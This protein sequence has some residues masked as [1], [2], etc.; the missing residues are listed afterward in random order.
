MGLNLI[1]PQSTF[2][3]GGILFIMST[4]IKADSRNKNTNP[5]TSTTK[6]KTVRKKNVE[7]ASGSSKKIKKK[8]NLLKLCSEMNKYTEDA[9]DKEIV[10]RFKTSITS[11][12]NE[13]ISKTNL[14]TILKKPEDVN[15]SDFPE[16]IQPYIK[17]Y[18]FMV[19]RSKKKK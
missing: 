6:A 11:S 7:K 19:N 14:I 8:V 9:N 5:V 15:M 1:S 10:K 4:K 16:N 18:I 3:F 17:H 2:S 13:D 12:V